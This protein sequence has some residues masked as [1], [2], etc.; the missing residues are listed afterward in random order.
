MK[1]FICLLSFTLL[2]TSES[3]FTQ[4]KTAETKIIYTGE[5]TPA[6]ND[7]EDCLS[8]YKAGTIVIN[9]T[10]PGDKTGQE[11]YL[12]VSKNK[13]IIKYTTE[14][15]LENA[16]YTYLDIL[17]F[18]WYGPGDNWFIKPQKLEIP[19]IDGKWFKPTFRNRSFFG[20]GGLNFGS[21]QPYDP[22]NTVRIK[23][24]NWMRRNR[25]NADFNG[26]GHKGQSFYLQNKAI[27][28][29]HPEWFAN[30]TGRKSGRI[31]IEKPGAV[32]IY[33]EWIRK[34]YNQSK[35]DFIALGVDPADG[36]GGADDPLPANIPGINNYADKWWWLANQ[37]AADY[38]DNNRVVVTMYA[39]GDGEENAR[40][41]DFKLA[42]NV[43]PVII[44]YA[45]QTAY[46][47]NEMVKKWAAAITGNMGLYDY[48]NITQWSKGLPQ[49]DIYNMVP[50]LR[51]WYENKVDGVYL[52]STN[53]TGPMGHSLWLTGQLLWNL[54]ENFDSL[55]DQ[56]L[57]DCFGKAAPFMKNMFDRWS[58]NYQDAAEVTFSLQD[59][60]KASNVIKKG[61]PEWNRI[62]ELKAYVH[63]MKMYYEHDGTQQSKDAIYKYLYSIH[64]L[65]LVQTAAFISQR[66]ITP[67][68][69][70]N[71]VPSGAGIR[72][73][74]EKAIENQFTKDWA[75]SSP[76]YQLTNFTF[77]FNKVKYFEPIPTNSWRFGGFQ[78]R[79]FFTAPFTGKV[80]LDAGAETNTP[81]KIFT[82]D[83]VIVSEKV[84]TDNSDYSEELTGRT[85]KLKHV[86]F[87]IQKGK[88]YHIQTRY[89][90]SRIKM[91]T[92][93]VVLFKNPGSSDFDNYQY[94]VQ[95]FYVPEDVN[96]IVFYDSQKEGLNR[97]GYFL[98]PNGEKLS[99]EETGFKNIYK[100]SVASEYRGKL[101]TADFGHP[102]W[103]LLNIPNISS[104][105]KFDYGEL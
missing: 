24:L 49:F 93:G 22:Q 61:S 13:T 28:D 76:P 29:Q 64:H 63:Y 55:Y 20:T 71:V 54:S 40:V 90:N 2:L 19:E 34:I 53:A 82:D 84:G 25:F 70:G 41:P 10:D 87:D 75:M 31:K 102:G 52:E 39:Y 35:D 98:T 42:H 43:Y 65:M 58:R 96:E 105:Q 57:S 44:P 27:L 32:E 97:R 33:K 100:V 12:G 62:N 16:I 30:E 68:D 37:V 66:Y 81:L 69:K 101:W 79:F 50:K 45:F 9:K 47:P 73:L 77:D 7:L 88:L 46:L 6:I 60:K 78:C 26:G 17:G 89:G 67:L 74:S 72:P 59:L 15:S 23:W 94:P 36:R 56:Y 48:W 99:R 38:S 85:W 4:N 80:S 1:I 83:S 8:L 86:S 92:P 5:G 104:L 18:R 51:F 14:N 21:V 11:F 3:G 95:Y 91:N 103:R